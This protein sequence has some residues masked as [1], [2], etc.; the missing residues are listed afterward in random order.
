[1]HTLDANHYPTRTDVWKAF[2]NAYKVRIA[3]TLGKKVLGW[4]VL[5]TPEE[6]AEYRRLDAAARVE[7]WERNQSHRLHQFDSDCTLDAHGM[8]IHCHVWHGDPCPAC[9]QR[10]YHM[11]TCPELEADGP[12]HAVMTKELFDLMIGGDGDE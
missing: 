2:P 3:S 12:A 10:G 5:E 6:H 7:R 1:M 4:Y 9:G 11:A 8:C